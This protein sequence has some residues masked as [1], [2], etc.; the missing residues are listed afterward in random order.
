VPARG[1]E[2]GNIFQLG[3]RYTDALDVAAL[4]AAGARRRLVMGSYGIG[5]SRVLACLVEQHHDARGIALPAA[6]AAADAHL[7]SLGRA[8]AA[9]EETAAELHAGCERAGLL[10]L[11]DDRDAR[12]GEQLADA[13]LIGATARVTLGAA[14]LADGTVE[15]VERRAGRTHLVALGEAVAALL[16]LRR[17][18]LRA[19]GALA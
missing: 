2:V 1:V 4:D 11:W 19:E 12:P 18:L 8:R 15:L 13:D 3:T 14:T 6:V 5:V 17:D 16:A 7:V 10:T 9:L